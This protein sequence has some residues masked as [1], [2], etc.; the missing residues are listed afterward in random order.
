MKIHFP[1]KKA[2]EEGKVIDGLLRNIEKVGD[3]WEVKV[4]CPDLSTVQNL[5]IGL[6]DDEMMMFQGSSE[7]TALKELYEVER[8]L[9][10][11]L[12]QAVQ[13]RWGDALPTITKARDEMR[14]IMTKM[15]WKGQF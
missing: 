1:K 14:R 12:Q 9:S 8:K 6:S 10:F 4:T 5:Y 11:S 2:G 3:A 7:Q 15:G 13:L